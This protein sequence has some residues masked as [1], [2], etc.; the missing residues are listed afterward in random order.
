MNDDSATG[1]VA[2]VQRDHRE[3]EQMIENVESSTG[4][5]RRQ[6]FDRLASK[7]KAHEHAEEAVVHPLAKD[8]GNAETVTELVDEETTA[9]KALQQLQGM[10]VDSGEFDAAFAKLKKDVLAHAQQ[11][12]RD[13]HPQI[14]HDTSAEELERRA[15]QFEQAEGDAAL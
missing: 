1:V 14:L 2:A 3:I 7:L 9:S 15:E 8:E 13:E 4:D 12:E 10:D 11:E 6:A 5:A